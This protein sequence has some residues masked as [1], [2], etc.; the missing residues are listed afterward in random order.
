MPRRIF[1]SYISFQWWQFENSYPEQQKKIGLMPSGFLRAQGADDAIDSN[2]LCQ[3]KTTIIIP[4]LEP[5]SL[6]HTE[7]EE[8]EEWAG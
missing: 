2:P 8:E 6:I 1:L 3:D 7:E 5:D 4:Y